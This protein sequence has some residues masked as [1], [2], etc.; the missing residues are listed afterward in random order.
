MTEDRPMS[1]PTDETADG[2]K[3]PAHDGIDIEA[4][5]RDQLTDL[6]DAI[7]TELA[8]RELRTNLDDASSIDLVSGK[9]ASWRSLSAHPNTKAVKPWIM[10]VTGEH[11]KYGVDGEWLAKQTIDGSHHMDVS[12]LN[13]GDIIKVSGASH[14]NKKHRY[15]RILAMRGE[16]MHY[17]RI[18]ET[19]TLET[20]A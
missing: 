3:E 14:N 15:Y 17:E 16:T 10:H 20:V 12:G 19:K 18:S 13:S 7:N 6:R 5:T 2:G 1:R 4:L 11:E 9:W 8:A